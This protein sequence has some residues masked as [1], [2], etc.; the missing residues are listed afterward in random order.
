MED[1]KQYR[2]SKSMR[3]I[4]D[5][6]FCVTSK[7]LM[8]VILLQNDINFGWDSMSTYLL[9]ALYS[10]SADMC[11][12]PFTKASLAP[13]VGVSPRRMGKILT[14][15]MDIDMIEQLQS[16]KK[17]NSQFASGSERHCVFIDAN[18]LSNTPAALF[19]KELAKQRKKVKKTNKPVA[20]LIN[21]LKTLD[22]AQKKVCDQK[23]KR[24][25]RAAVLKKAEDQKRTKILPKTKRKTKYTDKD[26]RVAEWFY[27]S[28]RK[29]NRE[30]KLRYE[31]ESPGHME[32]AAD[33][34]RLFREQ[35]KLTYKEIK[36][37]CLYAMLWSRIF[38]NDWPWKNYTFLPY[39]RGRFK[40]QV[41][42]RKLQAQMKGDK[43][44]QAYKKSRKRG[45][46]VEFKPDRV[47]RSKKVYDGLCDNL[48]EAFPDMYTKQQANQA[49]TFLLE[50]YDDK[51]PKYNEEVDDVCTFGHSTAD[52]MVN[53]FILSMPEEDWFMDGNFGMHVFNEKNKV[54]TNIIAKFKKKG[55]MYD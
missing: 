22:A 25:M 12:M 18:D 39:F 1:E 48:Q 38:G 19:F 44:Y 30:A 55:Y 32:K 20:P 53:D 33:T 31:D 16:Q 27:R 46:E 23:K 8:S 13:C 34:V 14:Y 21:T 41:R 26:M 5:A 2:V 37:L 51:G 50:Y 52:Q 10:E 17:N 42:W 54:F 28:H 40:D 36:E 4:L 24:S 35:D 6:D 15:L 11:R 49:I 7:K 29:Y 47:G 43:K 9:M 45:K 3:S